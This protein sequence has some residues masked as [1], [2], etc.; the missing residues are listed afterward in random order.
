MIEWNVDPEIFSLG[1]ISVRYYSLAFVITFLLGYYILKWIVIRENKPIALV[2]R[3][4]TYMFI[5]TLAGARLGHCLFYDPVY[6]LSNPLEIFMTWK[7][8]LASHGAAAGILIALYLFK[9]KTPEISYIWLMDR[10][11]IIISKLLLNT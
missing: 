3:L 10:I 5:A 6:Y 7:G 4:F 11:S 8:G 9:R 1:F 2:D